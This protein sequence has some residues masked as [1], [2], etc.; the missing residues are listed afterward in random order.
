MSAEVKKTAQEWM[1]EKWSSNGPIIDD[2][3]WS[4]LSEREK[5]EAISELEF[6]LR[7]AKPRQPQ[8]N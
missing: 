1:R 5:T 8:R 2:S 3:F 4:F 6:E 7:Y